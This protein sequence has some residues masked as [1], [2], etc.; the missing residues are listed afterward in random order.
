MEKESQF[1]VQTAFL[2][3]NVCRENTNLIEKFIE[4]EENLIQLIASKLNI[5]QTPKNIKENAIIMQFLYHVSLKEIY[6]A[7]IL[8]T[9]VF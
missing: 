2:V 4:E 9:G 6:R 1:V 3:S 5:I 8:K 7:E